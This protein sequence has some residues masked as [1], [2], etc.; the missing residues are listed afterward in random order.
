VKALLNY[1]DRQ[2]EW[3]NRTTIP[4]ATTENLRGMRTRTPGVVVVSDDLA[5]AMQA[6]DVMRAWFGPAGI[7]VAA[8]TELVVTE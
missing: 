1:A 5:S 3:P 7:V 4:A 8:V 2:H 6:H